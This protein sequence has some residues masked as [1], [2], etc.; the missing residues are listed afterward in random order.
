M[1]S[2]LTADCL[3]AI[4]GIKHGFFTREGGTSAGL[5]KTLNCGWGAKDDTVAVVD[6][7]ARVAQ[8]L[9]AS[10]NEVLTLYQAHSATAFKATGMIAR[11][12]LP[13]ADAI[14]TAKRGLVIGVLT[15]DCA[16]VLFAGDDGK[17][18]GAAHAGWRGAAGGI[19]EATVAAMEEL[20]AKRGSIRASLGPCINQQAYEVGLEFEAELLG[21]SPAN[22]RFFMKPKGAT[23]P[24]FD[25]PGYVEA[26]LKS[27]G[28]AKVER[29]SPCTH[30]NESLF[31]SYRRSTQRSE[32]DYGRQISAIVVA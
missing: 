6:N 28:V 4:S 13:Q 5:Y 23:K 1:L 3:T 24:R 32:A 22:S 26:R 29:N 8:H 21:L 18:V 20:G 17:V 10:A 19:L 12:A 9:G 15:A 27:S 14:V 25:L 31:Y 11:D 16:P 30:R 7:R 2:P